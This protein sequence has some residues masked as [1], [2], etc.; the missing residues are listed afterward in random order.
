MRLAAAYLVETHAGA[1]PAEP[2]PKYRMVRRKEFDRDYAAVNE[3]K[4]RYDYRCQICGMTIDLGGGRSYCEGHHLRP[5]GRDHDGSDDV[6]NVVILCPNHHTEFD[7][8]LF[9]ILDFTGKKR[10][11]E[12]MYRELERNERSITIK[13]RIARENVDYV[14]EQ[15]LTRLDLYFAN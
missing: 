14:I 11:V 6:S 4:A 13:H 5:L 3:L 1:V 7:Y 10:A 2:E 15:F 8:F 9:A 12:H